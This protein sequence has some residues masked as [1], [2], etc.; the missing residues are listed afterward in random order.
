MHWLNN[1]VPNVFESRWNSAKQIYIKIH[2]FVT[3]G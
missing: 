3:M 2:V 1:E